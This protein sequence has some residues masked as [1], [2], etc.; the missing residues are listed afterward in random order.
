MFRVTEDN[1]VPWHS[2]PEI[3]INDHAAGHDPQKSGWLYQLYHPGKA[4]WMKQ[5]EREVGLTL[6]DE[7]DEFRGAGEWNHLYLKV[8]PGECQVM[9]NGVSYYKFQLGSD[10]WKNRVSQSKFAKFKGFGMAETGHI[11]LQD[12]GNLVAFRN[13][14]IRPLP[15][16]GV[17]P[18]PVDG[19]L[20]LK[21]EPAFPNLNWDGWESINDR[22]QV[23][24][25]RP[26][27]IT[28]AGDGT[29]RLFVA[30]QDGM[31]FSL[32]PGASQAELFLDLRPQVMHY[33]KGH[34]EEGL[35]GL[36][37]HPQFKENGQF[38]VYYTRNAPGHT[39]VVSRF[40]VSADAAN[41]ADPQSEEIV[42][43][44]DEP[45]GNHNGGS[46]EFGPDGY[47]YLG[48]GD[49]GSG[50]DPLGNGQNL[51]TL[52]GKIL[53]IDVDARDGDLAYAIP[54]DNP[55]VNLDGARPEIFA[56]GFRNPWR[57][58]FD[59]QTGHLWAG[60]VGQDYWEEIHLVEPG[61]NYGWSE[62]EGTWSFGNDSWSTPTEPTGPVWQYDH[63]VG[64]SITGGFVYRGRRLPELDGV[65]LY[66]DY[67]TGRIWGLKYDTEARKVDWNK[68]I[69]AQN[70]AVLAF[71]EDE[72]GDVYFGI[73]TAAGNGIYRFVQSE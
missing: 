69:P 27:C 35:L 73:A 12:H 17:P 66:A 41:Q 3:Q 60:E 30:T 43:T 4:G 22:G 47:L 65:Y 21:V 34:N 50:N 26:V 37:F 56:Y 28:H 29:N 8:T 55:F 33:K 51:E 63:L 70:M 2:G 64:R 23:N 31:V 19:T 25:M 11:C 16:S 49:G 48:I 61:G 54:P 44:I 5:V 38:F 40:H 62:Q 52:L 13:I 46:I 15:A 58:S 45:F 10:D 42:M 59:R 39:S 6:P 68:S 9:L 1:P 18:Q 36:A 20:A 53:R 32:T 7:V 57:I 71:G 24:E 72:Q 14:K 67:V